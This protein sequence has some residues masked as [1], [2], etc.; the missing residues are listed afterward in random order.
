MHSFLIPTQSLFEQSPHFT[1]DSNAPRLLTYAT[2][3][4]VRIDSHISCKC[5]VRIEVF[6][7]T[8]VGGILTHEQPRHIG[9]QIRGWEIF[10]FFLT[11]QQPLMCQGFPLS[12]LRDH[13]QAHHTWWDLDRRRE[14]YLT[15]DNTQR[16]SY[17]C[18]WRDSIPQSQQVSCHRRTS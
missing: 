18:S 11:A 16:K 9:V 4:F 2:T 12:S 7:A 17:P 6:V 15:T 8:Q 1:S 3:E 5:F 13:T 14:L 10:T